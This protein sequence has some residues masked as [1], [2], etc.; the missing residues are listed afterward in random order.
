MLS[1]VIGQNYVL[2]GTVDPFDLDAQPHFHAVG[3]QLGRISHRESLGCGAADAQLGHH[4]AVVRC[5]GFLAHHQQLHQSR[6]DGGGEQFIHET[7]SYGPESNNN[8]ALAHDASLTCSGSRFQLE[9]FLGGDCLPDHTRLVLNSGMPEMGSVVASVRRLAFSW[10][11]EVERQE[12][13]VRADRVAELGTAEH[14]TA[15][16]CHGGVVAV[17]NAA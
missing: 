4:H 13:S 6:A 15:L 1:A 17:G 10:P 2:T 14:F 12:D 7:G 9:P 16:I 5:L 3:F 8:N 11:G